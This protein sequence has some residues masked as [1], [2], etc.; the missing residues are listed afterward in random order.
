M[1]TVYWVA[2]DSAEGI[3]VD[4]G[5]ETGSFGGFSPVFTKIEA[6]AGIQEPY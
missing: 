2:A 5:Y 6:V 4:V 3:S 1:G